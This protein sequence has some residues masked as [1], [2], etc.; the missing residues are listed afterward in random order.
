MNIQDALLKEHSRKQA[1]K[2]RDYIEKDSKKFAELMSHFLSNNYRLAQRAAYS[3]NLIGEK[4][5]ELVIPYFSKMVLKL[6]DGTVHNSVKRNTVRLF[7]FIDIPKKLHSK[8]VETCFEL[9]L[10][11]NE[12]LAIR[13]FSMSVLHKLCLIY[14][15][16][17]NE[18]IP[19]IE[20]ELSQ[21]PSPA[22][23]SRGNK[24]LKSLK[25]RKGIKG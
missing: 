1:E 23:I 3:V 11:K 2:I 7:Q 10:N 9:L 22:F 20:I 16:L 12:A 24:V 14:P 8:V 13:V 18:L 4:H 6:S 17:C 25:K 19:I 5:P 15:E 21:N